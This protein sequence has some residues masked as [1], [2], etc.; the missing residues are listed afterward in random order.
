MDININKS[1]NSEFDSVWNMV[2]KYDAGTI[3]AFRHGPG[4]G[5]HG[6]Y[7]IHENK[8]N[9]TLLKS[10]LLSLGYNITTVDAIYIENYGDDSQKKIKCELYIV[11]DTN[12]SGR[13]RDDLIQLGNLFNQDSVTVSR[14]DGSHNII[15]T[16]KCQSSYPGRG[17]IGIDVSLEKPFFGD[18]GEIYPVIKGRPFVFHR[19]ISEPQ[20]INQYSIS[21]IRSIKENSK[22]VDILGTI[23]SDKN[24]SLNE[25]THIMK[26]GSKSLINE[27][28]ISYIH[29]IW[30]QSNQP[31]FAILTA[32]TTTNDNSDPS[33]TIKLE[34]DI[35]QLI[36]NNNDI[37]YYKTE[38]YW[39]HCINSS[40]TYETC[41][42][43]YLKQIVEKSFFVTGISLEDAKS[44]ASKYGAEAFIY[45]GKETNGLVRIVDADTNDMYT[46]F[47]KFTPNTIRLAYTA[48][49]DEK[50]YTFEGIKL[51]NF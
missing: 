6:K 38:G 42:A 37:K 48:S 14:P 24:V 51:K 23:R 28:S 12:N 31:P 40:Y 25:V 49:K 33:D 47:G 36:S 44:I 22:I 20:K 50:L 34:N 15:G 8:E 41:P 32:Y 39:T 43:E 19:R 9:S 27:V 7:T 4:C 46:T 1:F 5:E 17:K 16:S 35:K 29:K 11:V 2:S 10:K 21:E 18:N 26:H 13:L 45:S 30:K 3:S